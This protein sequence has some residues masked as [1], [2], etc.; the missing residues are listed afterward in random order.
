MMETMLEPT[1][2]AIALAIERIAQ[3]AQPSRIIA[4]G[5]RAR[6]KHRP[7][8]DLDLLVLLPHGSANL[9]ISGDVYEAVGALGFSKDILISDEVRFK[10]FGGPVNSVQAE[11]ARDGITL[12]EYGRTNRSAIEKICR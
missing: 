4:F 7:D 12:Y 1:P 6:G 8:S 2:A 5:S 3:T 11:A 9:D 10:Q